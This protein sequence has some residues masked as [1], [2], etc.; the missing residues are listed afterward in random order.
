M[1]SIAQFK[2]TDSL[3]R[4]ASQSLTR[5]VAH[6][7][8]NFGYISYG[9]NDEAWFIEIIDGKKNWEPRN[10]MFKRADDVLQIAEVM[11]YSIAGTAPHDPMSGGRRGRSTVNAIEFIAIDSKSGARRHF[12]F[13]HF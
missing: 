12:K 9:G 11:S 3:A 8:K 5:L 2:L 4:S 6:L 10:E 1:P 7:N 13:S